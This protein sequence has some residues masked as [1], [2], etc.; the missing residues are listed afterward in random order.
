[1]PRFTCLFRGDVMA[2]VNSGDPVN[3]LRSAL[4]AYVSVQDTMIAEAAKLKDTRNVTAV[5]E[6]A[7]AEQ[8]TTGA[9]PS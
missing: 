2:I 8:G 6:P 9:V 4:D 5:G 3:T 1:M 7:P